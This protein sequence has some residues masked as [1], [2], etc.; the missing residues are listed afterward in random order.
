MPI[1]E[2]DEGWAFEKCL[3]FGQ[4]GQYSGGSRLNL[5]CLAMDRSESAEIF[6]SAAILYASFSVPLV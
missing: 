6:C 3:A 2:R 4:A 1:L 5:L